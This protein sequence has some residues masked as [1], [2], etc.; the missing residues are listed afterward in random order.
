MHLIRLGSQFGFR[1][2]G[3]R[4]VA[5]LVLSHFVN[6]EAFCRDLSEPSMNKV[7]WAISMR[8]VCPY[9]PI[10]DGFKSRPNLNENWRIRDENQK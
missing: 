10:S 6:N 4:A 8:T 7:A 1:I 9:L 2:T 3:E 5:M